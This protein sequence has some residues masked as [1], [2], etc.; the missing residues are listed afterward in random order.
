MR[1]I[2]CFTIEEAPYSPGKYFITPIHAN[3]H[4]QST[5]GS[6]N[7]IPARL[8]GLSY[9]QYLR[10]C[11]DMCQAEIVGKGTM[12]PIPYFRKTNTLNALVRML[13][14]RANCVLWERDHIEWLEDESAIEEWNKEYSSIWSREAAD[15]SHS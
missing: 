7:V 8:M 2:E 9:A 3:F 6:F 12:Y 13:N 5:Q 4:L 10:F 14:L 15:V 1:R 11:R